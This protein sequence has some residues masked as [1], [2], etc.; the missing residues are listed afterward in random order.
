MTKLAQTLRSPLVLH[1]SVAAVFICIMLWDQPIV[2]AALPI[3]AL[4]FWGIVVVRLLQRWLEARVM[5]RFPQ[6]V[7]PPAPMQAPTITGTV[8]APKDEAEGIDRDLLRDWLQSRVIGQDTIADQLARGV[9][10]RMSQTSRGRPV[11][12][13]LISGPTGTGKTE[14]AKALAAYLLGDENAMFRV[15]CANV[16][17]EAGLQT[18]IGSPKGFAGSNSWGSLTAHLRANPRSIILFDEIEKAVTSPS[19]PLAKLLLSFLDEGICTEQSDGTRVSAA[20]SVILMTSN[21]AQA[22][23][24]AIYSRYKHDV[25][26]LQRA[27][28]DALGDYFA[29]E[30]LARIDLVTTTAPITTDAKA[31][32]VAMHSGRIA[33]SFGLEL[34]S[35]DASFINEALRVWV[36]FE[37]YG[38]RE[39]VRWIENVVADKMIELSKSGAGSASLA[40]AGGTPL[41]VP[42]P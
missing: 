35:V 2:R 42:S 16:L 4:V 5:K 19:A 9:H 38:V 31:Q 24:G 28:K 32:I 25:N 17:G 29:P 34:T 26:A 37:D 1:L 40:W 8:A 14:I 23:L 41:L 7:V 11:F 20:Q 33:R 13:C 30:F 3:V 6:A 18:L 21:A 39:V 36:E 22:E 12:T 10:R 15:D 27:T